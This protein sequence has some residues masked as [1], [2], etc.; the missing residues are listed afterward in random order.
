MR[1]SL[2]WCV[3]EVSMDGWFDPQDI[4]NRQWTEN[5]RKQHRQ[6]DL[7][8]RQERPDIGC[9]EKVV[10]GKIPGNPG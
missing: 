2:S 4:G 7:L 1:F 3:G 5:D 9:V 10:R 6:D 8:H